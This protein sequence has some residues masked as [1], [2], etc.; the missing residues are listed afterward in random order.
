MNSD[1]YQI[2]KLLHDYKVPEIYKNQL[3]QAIRL[4]GPEFG[5]PYL[6]NHKNGG[7][8]L[9]FEEMVKIQD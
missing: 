1:E 6:N 8:E 4:H 3:S 2:Q 9:N 5:M 7:V